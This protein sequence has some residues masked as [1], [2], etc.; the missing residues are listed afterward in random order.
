[1]ETQ[2]AD[3]ACVRRVLGGERN[4]YGEIVHRYEKR[5][6]SLVL[7][8]TRDR[9]GAEEVTQ[10]AFL[11]AHSNLRRYD[12]ERPLYPWLAT[13][14]VRLASN[15]QRTAARHRRSDPDVDTEDLPAHNDA[16]PIVE[17]ARH[18]AE[19]ALWCH[20]S[21][22]PKGERSAVLMFYKQDLTA[23][24]IAGILGVTNGTIKTFLHRGRM[25]LRTRLETTGGM[26]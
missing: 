14:A 9:G 11:R 10:D 24:E 4:A 18:Q 25:H 1:M 19:H 23:S 15:W 2:A 16:S 21:T 8:M 6:F 3:S 7:M 22:L 12:Q 17:L 5:L 20:V 13:I 26:P